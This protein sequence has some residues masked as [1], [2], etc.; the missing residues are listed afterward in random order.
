MKKLIV[1]FSYSGNTRKLVNELNKEFKYDVKEIERKVPYS[2][3][4]EECAYKEAKEEV[5]KNIHPEIK[6]LNF[7]MNQYD[8]ILL[9]FPIWWYTFP[10]PIGTFID[11]IKGYKGKVTLFMNSYT[12]DPQYA[13]NSLNDFKKVDSSIN[14]EV[15]LFNKSLREHINFLKK[16]E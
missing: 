10:M 9:F 3:V 11:S 6:P 8:E 2:S 13:K 4:Y 1:F 5:E 14:V 16:G 15:G 7:D 12:N